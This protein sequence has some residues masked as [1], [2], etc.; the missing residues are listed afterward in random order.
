MSEIKRIIPPLPDWP[1]TEANVLYELD[2]RPLGV[3]FWLAV[4]KARLWAE[5]PPAAREHLF[6]RASSGEAR[7][8]H[9]AAA[10]GAPE[11]RDAL[12]VFACLIDRTERVD[13]SMIAHA[14]ARI[15]DWAAD[16][17][18]FSTAT[19]FALAAA[20]VF[21]ENAEFSNLAGLMFRR[22][23]DFSRAE[24]CYPRA[25]TLSYQQ[26][27]WVE[28]ICGHI[29]SAAL[30][31]TKGINLKKAVRHLRTAAR[32]AWKE[33]MGWLAGHAIHD[34]MLLLLERGDFDAA[35]AAAARAA[36]LYP[37]HDRRFPFFVADYA[38]VQLM[39][40][41]YAQAH[42]LLKLCLDVIDQPA[43][44]GVITSM[45]ART[46]VGLGRHDEYSRFSVW[47]GEFAE[48]YREFSAAAHY[49]LAE[50]ARMAGTWPEA[51]VHAK[52]A[53]ELA[54]QG[55]DRMVARLAEQ[56]LRWTEA[57]VLTPGPRVHEAG[58]DLGRV[59]SIRL[60][61]WSP[62]EHRGPQ[63]SVFRNQWVA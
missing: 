17:S 62:A 28:Y 9:R 12:H 27:N 49:H 51:E 16:R 21:P 48:K 1:R 20:T 19:H 34:S 24:E 10:A 45:L 25:I 30:L 40:R 61:H 53:W 35:E 36:K 39:Q 42:P 29:G 37:L 55:Q 13:D 11:L 5:T 63:R 59:L 2:F 56:L 7:A 14:C 46:A 60:Q 54:E 33:G 31:Y 4:R 6:P 22:A 3:E 23:G 32:K 8:R 18:F 58:D 43:A 57:R 50:A 41:R 26:R 15:A 38:L 52:R 44:R 47:A